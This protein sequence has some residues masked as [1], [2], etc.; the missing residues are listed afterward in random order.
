MYSL[1]GFMLRIVDPQ[2]ITNTAAVLQYVAY[3]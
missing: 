3:N 2:R 1:H